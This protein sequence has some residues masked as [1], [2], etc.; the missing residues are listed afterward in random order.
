MAGLNA[1]AARMSKEY[2]ATAKLDLPADIRTLTGFRPRPLQ[3]AI[4]DRS[5][6][7]NSIVVH[8]RFGK[9]V[10]AVNKIIERAIN[11]PFPQGRYAYGGPTYDQVEDI[12]WTYLKDFT[13]NIPGV[14]VEESKLAVTVPTR[15]GDRARIRLYGLDS[16]KQR[17]RGMYL[18]GIV[19]DEWAQIPPHVWTQQIRPMLSDRERM[20]YD[21]EMNP[22]QWA[23]F[24]FTPFGQNHAYQMHRRA[25]AWAAGQS[26]VLGANAAEGKEG[27][28]VSRTDW[29]AELWPASRTGVLSERELELA[30][31]DA[32]DDNEYQ[33]EF[34]CSFDAAIKGAIL[35]ARLSELKAAGRIR[36]VPYNPLLPVHTG[37]DLGVDDATAIWFAQIVGQERRIIDYYEASGAGLDHYADVLEKRGYRYGKHYLPHD[38]EVTELGSGKSRASILRA[39]GVRVTTVARHKVDDR[40]AAMRAFLPGCYIDNVKAAEGLE[41]LASYR[42]DYDPRQ[43]VYR[44]QPKHDWASHGADAFGTL[45][46]GLRRAPPGADDLQAASAVM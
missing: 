34:E 11:C 32:D 3:Q 42:R 9:T 6:R 2:L 18:D 46:M 10:L 24:I 13:A 14:K 21:D 7:F 36:H 43:R 22:N 26:V 41:R 38:V 30:K 20:G 35:A 29:N 16:P 33:Q 8:R 15:R 40:I 17:V 12:V 37:W 27:E 25:T 31:Q 19:L 39:M 1:L 28:T 45:V 44:Q 4:L 5:K 23:D